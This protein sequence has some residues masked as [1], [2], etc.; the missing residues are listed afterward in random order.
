M[1]YMTVDV[2]PLSKKKDGPQR[3][4]NSTRRVTTLS[5]VRQGRGHWTHCALGENQA[6]TASFGLG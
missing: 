3:Q 6:L 1:G 4:N 5:H 2:Y